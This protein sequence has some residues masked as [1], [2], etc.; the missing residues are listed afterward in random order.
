MNAR[1]FR[2]L[3]AVALRRQRLAFAAWIGSFCLVLAVVPNAYRKN[4]GSMELRR[5]VIEMM[6]SNAA[7]RLLFGT[8]PQPGTVG[9]LVQ[10]CRS[11][12]DAADVVAEQLHVDAAEQFSP[13]PQDDDDQLVGDIAGHS[14]L[15]DPATHPGEVFP[16][17]RC[18]FR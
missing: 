4:L 9:Q 12:L 14:L 18:R 6:N 2:T 16:Q 17:C 15:T 7:T 13:A 10:E 8:V 11:V 1:D 5:S 3:F